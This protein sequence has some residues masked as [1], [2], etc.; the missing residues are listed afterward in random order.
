M[1]FESTFSICCNDSHN[2]ARLE[3][4]VLLLCIKWRA[5]PNGHKQKK[6]WK[7]AVREKS[8]SLIGHKKPQC[9][10]SK[11]LE[12]LCSVVHMKSGWQ[13]DEDRDKTDQSSSNKFESSYWH[14][15]AHCEANHC[16]K[17]DNCL[18]LN[19]QWAVPIATFSGFIIMKML[20]RTAVS[21]GTAKKNSISVILKAFYWMSLLSSLFSVI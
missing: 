8:K 19:C 7:S 6:K 18:L 11:A 9:H 10:Y 21:I 3:S 4:V 17:W 1:H 14:P 5:V 13:R 2:R 15:Q 16:V 12:V 20:K